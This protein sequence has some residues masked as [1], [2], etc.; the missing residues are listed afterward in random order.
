[1]FGSRKAWNL[2]KQFPDAVKA[3]PGNMVK[4]VGHM[5]KEELGMTVLPDLLFGGVAAGFA[6]GDATDKALAGLGAGLGGVT[7]GLAIRSAIPGISKNPLG[8]LGAEMV[9]GIGGDIAGSS[10]ANSI[11]TARHGGVSPMEQQRVAYENELKQQAVDE[12][13]REQGLA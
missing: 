12:F 11:S 4:N 1:M 5:G 6:E 13:L 10:I 9:G 2:L 8:I 7:G 3:L